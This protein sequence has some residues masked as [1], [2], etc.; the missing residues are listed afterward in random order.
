M[1]RY[2]AKLQISLWPPNQATKDSYMK[3]NEKKKQ[4]HPEHDP[5]FNHDIQ[6]Q[7]DDGY[8]ILIGHPVN[9]WSVTSY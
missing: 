4:I 1:T 9:S 6:L 7:I 2:A 8:V 3:D 5:K